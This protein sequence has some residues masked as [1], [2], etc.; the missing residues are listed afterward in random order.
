MGRCWIYGKLVV[1]D[2]GTCEVNGFCKVGTNGVATKADSK[3]D[4]YR[5]MNRIDEN[6][7]R[8]LLK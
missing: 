8:I 6:T 5:V 2:D 3:I 1:I 4:A 7:I